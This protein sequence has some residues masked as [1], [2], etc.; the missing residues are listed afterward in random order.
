MN[1]RDKLNKLLEKNDGLILTEDIEKVNIPRQYLSIFLKE[2]KLE[3]ISYGVYKKPNAV[4]DELYILQ[5]KNK[6]AIFSHETSL[7]LLD[8]T[9]RDPINYSVTVP[10]GY[11]ATHLRKKELKGSTPNHIFFEIKNVFQ[12]LESIGSA[13]IEG[14]HTTISEFVEKFIPES[15]NTK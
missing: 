7:F 9:D 1:Y 12:F 14:N 4:E 5:R 3:K 13:R 2:N 8:L 10:Y 6:K 15:L 11:N